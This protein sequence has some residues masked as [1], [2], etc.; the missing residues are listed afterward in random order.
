VFFASAFSAHRAAGI[1]LPF[2]PRV[3]PGAR[4]LCEMPSASGKSA[5]LT[6][7]A[8]LG[9]RTGFPYSLTLNN[10][11][12]GN[13]FMLKALTFIGL[14]AVVALTPVVVLAQNASP[15]PS[16]THHYSG[17]KPTGSF[18]SEMRNRSLSSR[19]RARASAEHVRMMRR[20]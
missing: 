1:L 13:S 11:L 15:S 16:T 8:D 4:L 9:R 10:R 17:H 6:N 12:G 5:H 18:R 19:E 20:Q 7:R 2:S 14:G 3:N